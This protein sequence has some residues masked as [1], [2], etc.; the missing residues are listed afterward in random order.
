[1][2]HMV[3]T[4]TQSAKGGFYVEFNQWMREGDNGWSTN[5]EIGFI[6]MFLGRASEPGRAISRL[7]ALKRYQ[8][9]IQNR[10]NWGDID[11]YAIKD[12]VREAIKREEGKA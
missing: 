11:R 5:N 2:G 7:E 10:I 12:F 3:R 4:E 9:T 6:Q 1:M 8:G